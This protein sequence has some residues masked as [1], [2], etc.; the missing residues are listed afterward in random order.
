VSA[1]NTEGAAKHTP[2]SGAV[3]LL[4]KEAIADIIREH[5]GDTYVCGRV[6][7]AWNVGTMS[8]N[9]FT[10]AAECELADDAADA[11][12]AAI[13]KATGSTPC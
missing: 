7:A 3:Q 1:V 11:I 13:A 12:R 2:A 5:L 8:K 10:P 9:D 4:S 6:W